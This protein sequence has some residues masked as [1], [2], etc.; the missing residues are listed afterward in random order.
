MTETT[1]SAPRTVKSA[2]RTVELLL[3]LAQPEGRLG[4]A[5]IARRLSM[6]KSSAHSLVTTLVAQGALTTDRA[7]DYALAPHFLAVIDDAY[8]RLDIRHAA[9]DVMRDVSSRLAATCN[10]AT[11]DGHDVVYVDQVRDESHP[12]QLTTHIGVRIPAHATALGKVLV[13]EMSDTTRNAWMGAH[14]FS[15]MTGRTVESAARMHEEIERY[16]RLGYATDDEELH[17]GVL[18]IAA[19]VRDSSGDAVGAI[20]VTTIKSRLLLSSD[21]AKAD[22]GTALREAGQMISRRLGWMG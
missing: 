17:E 6:P 12:M 21:D 20:S 1:R 10:L 19:P 8:K 5:E 4:L 3:L 13:A 7:G 11:L 16:R 2:K 9:I 14:T 18:C 15:A 22:A